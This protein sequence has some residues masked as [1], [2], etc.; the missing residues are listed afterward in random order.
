MWLSLTIR[1]LSSKIIANNI[2]KYW[3]EVFGRQGPYK[4]NGD[5]IKWEALIHDWSI[6]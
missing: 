6:V 1:K 3:P 5:P 2:V 4:L